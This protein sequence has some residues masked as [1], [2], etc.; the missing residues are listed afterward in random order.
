MV[1]VLLLLV[2]SL[3]LLLQTDPVQNWLIGKVTGWLS[4]SLKTTV[5]VRHVNFIPFNQASL[6]GVLVRDQHKD[7]LFYAG[8]V[9]VNITDWPFLKKSIDLKYIDLEDARII[10]SRTDSTWN[11][12]FLVDYFSGPSPTPHQ[13]NGASIGLRE[14]QLKN[15]HVAQIDKWKGQDMVL[16]VGSLHLLA[17][18][19]NFNTKKVDVDELSTT[20]LSFALSNYPGNR[21]DS[22]KPPPTKEKPSAWNPDGWELSA[23]TVRL[24]DCRFQNNGYTPQRGPTSYFDGQHIDFNHVDGHLDRVRMTGDTLTCTIALLKT[25]ERSGL[26]VK[27]LTAKFRFTPHIM[28]F[29]Q[30]DVYTNRSRIKDYFAMRYDNFSDDM[31]DYVTRINMKGDIK[32][33]QVSTDDIAYFAPEL[34]D[35]NK[36][37]D[38]SGQV[39]GPVSALRGHNLLLKSGQTIYINGDFAMTGLPDI[40]RTTMNFQLADL[41]CDWGDICVIVPSLR[42][43]TEPNMATLKSVRFKGS[44]TGMIRDFNVIGTMQTNLGL[45]TSNLNMKLPEKGSASYKGQITTSGFDLGQFLGVPAMGAFSANATVDGSGFAF[46]NLDATFKGQIS[47]A[48]VNNYTYQNINIQGSFKK[49]LFDGVLS[50]SDPNAAFS[51]EGKVQLDQASP[52]FDIAADV[53]RLNFEPLGLINRDLAFTGKLALNFKGRNIDDFT[54]TAR[55][56]DATL[57]N[58]GEPLAFD[59]LTLASDT[60]AGNNRVLTLQSLPV[61]AKVEG[62]YHILELPKIVQWYLGKYYPSYI[63]PIPEPP[64]KEDFSFS[65]H[66]DDVEDYLDLLKLPM[67]GLD[68]SDVSGRISTVDHIF[69]VDIN[70]PEFSYKQ[71]DFSDIAIKTQG[72]DEKIKLDGSLGE[73]IVTD[74]LRFPSTHLSVSA[75]NDNSIITLQTAATQNLTAAT[76]TMKVHNTFDGVSAHFD[77]SSFVLN[78]KKWLIA[79]DGEIDVKKDWIA[80]SNL[81]M[82]SSLEQIDLSTHPSPDNP[83]SNDIDADLTKV[84][85]EDILPL[86][87]KEPHMEGQMTGKI[88]IRNPFGQVGIDAKTHLDQFHFESDSIGTV[89]A[90]AGY[91]GNGNV[92]FDITSQNPHYNF[93]MGG[94]LVLGDSSNRSINATVNLDNT[95]MHLLQPYLGIIFSDMEGSATGSIQVTGPINAP[96]LVGRVNVKKGML[97]VNYT[98][99]KYLFDDEDIDFKPGMI[100]FGSITLRDTLGNTALFTGSLQH[101]FFK[102]MS[103]NLRMN[104]DRILALN[105]TARDNK[106][107]YGTAIAKVNA[108]LT[109]PQSNILL[110]IN[111]AEPVDSSHIYLPSNNA[112]AGE[113]P[114]FIVFKEYGKEMTADEAAQQRNTTTNFTVQMNLLVN[115][116]AKIDVILDPVNGDVVKAQG[117]GNLVILIGTATPLAINGTYNIESGEYTYSYANFGIRKPFSLSQGNIRWTGDPYAAYININA[118][119]LA[120]DVTLPANFTSSTGV[121]ITETSNIIILCHL[122]NT[123]NHPDINFEFQLPPDNP[124]K[125]DPIVSAELKKYQEDKSEMN[126]QVTSLLLFDT[127]I[128][129]QDALA[130]NVSGGTLVAGTVGQVVA[131]QLSTTLR[132]LI[133]KILK[134]N[135]IDPYIT[136]N[137]GFAFQGNQQLYAVTNASKLGVNKSFISGRLVFKLGTSLDYST[138]PEFAQK[139]TDLLW[140]PDLAVQW[141]ISPDGHLR[142]GGYNHT[143]YD[144]TYGRYNRSGIS[145][146]YRKDFDRIIDLFEK[147]RKQ[148][149]A[150]RPKGP[151]PPPPPPP[152]QTIDMKTGTN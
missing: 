18:D 42:T 5:S 91:A 150:K 14:V 74:S 75:Q 132:A 41:R 37:V 117:N 103:F 136:I 102:D 107:F 39:E 81:R 101:T 134:D 60:A 8:A 73:I 124:Y 22:L 47:S 9:N 17:N 58:A 2:L 62:Q 66:T 51:M 56:F 85:I 71:Y 123:L 140:S 50:I 141:S 59:S 118:S 16:D 130:S 122:T 88:T 104:S 110:R 146:N 133:K 80:I 70:V 99:C 84:T 90:E 126:K 79:S 108:S 96:Q 148:V 87:F 114:D 93:K 4:K 68:N 149:D 40:D 52:V 127:F 125:N 10:A 23:S 120:T 89:N 7:T 116:Y 1:A 83:A 78:D 34:K 100:D 57:N 35:W 109:G 129:S 61:T 145:L 30:L 72:N 44:Y 82:S 13:K 43:L 76:L 92:K 97:R 143:I 49:K 12:Q 112:K 77:S 26:E 152:P 137:P 147:E 46:D 98:Q 86:F 128:S 67:T 64:L 36:L 106:N 142:L 113:L 119:Y 138:S 38:V 95:S 121:T 21:P 24:K 6:Q 139:G 27:K 94:G 28:E 54:G 33:S 53:T 25:R 115:N 19:I 20:D 48:N 131:G 31:G 151:P 32:N 55:V 11:Y 15:V 65:V 29:R 105:T 63:K 45:V 3:W 144:L 111:Q 135:T 69:N